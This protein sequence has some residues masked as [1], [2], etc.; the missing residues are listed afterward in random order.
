MKLQKTNEKKLM[1]IQKNK[2]AAAKIKKQIYQEKHEKW[3]EKYERAKIN[4]RED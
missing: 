4:N 3:L 1:K 2:D